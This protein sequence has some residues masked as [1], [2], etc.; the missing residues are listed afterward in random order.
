V[1]VVD[2]IVSPEEL[3][4]GLGTAFVVKEPLDTPFGDSVP[5]T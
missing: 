4:N 2:A 3:G 5:Q 1:A